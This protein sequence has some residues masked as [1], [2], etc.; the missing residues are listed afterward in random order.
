MEKQSLFT[1]ILDLWMLK[2]LSSPLRGNP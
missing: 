1:G 2:E